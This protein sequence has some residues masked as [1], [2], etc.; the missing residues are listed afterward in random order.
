[1]INPPVANKQ[2]SERSARPN[3]DYMLNYIPAGL[4]CTYRKVCVFYC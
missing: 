3:E 1:M 4:P 2:E